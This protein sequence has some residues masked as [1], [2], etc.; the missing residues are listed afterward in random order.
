MTGFL[1]PQ[2]STGHHFGRGGIRKSHVH[3]G[4]FWMDKKQT[5]VSHNSTKA[6]I[7]SLDAGLRMDGIPA[8]DL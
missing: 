8:L 2:N 3:A 4:K 1:I 5:S 6:E 7:I